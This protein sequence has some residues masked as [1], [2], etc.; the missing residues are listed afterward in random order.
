MDGFVALDLHDKAT[1][2]L[3]RRLV[4]ETYRKQ[5]PVNEDWD[6]RDNNGQPV[7]PGAYTWKAVARPPFKL[8]YET[9]V[10]NSGIPAWFAPRPPKAGAVG[11]RTTRWP[12]TLRRRRTGSGFPLPAPK[13][14]TP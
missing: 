14:D 4:G 1:G 6:L 10:Y 7:S 5:G 8:T 2:K 9:S 11:S 13:A 12:A 3:V